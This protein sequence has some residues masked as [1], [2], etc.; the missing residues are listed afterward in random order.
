MLRVNGER[1]RAH[2]E[3]LGS[4]GALPEGGVNRFTYSKEYYAGVELLKKYMSEAGMETEVDPVGNVIGTKKGRSDRIL[5]MGSTS[6][7]CPTPVSL[8]A[9][10]ACC[11]PLRRWPR[12]GNRAWS[13]ITP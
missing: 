1:L 13:W 12:C 9:A 2:L 10:S 6:T 11:P 5:L 8:T 3:E 7:A 4:I